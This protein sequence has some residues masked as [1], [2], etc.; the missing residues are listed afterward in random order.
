MIEKWALQL[1]YA[2][3]VAL[4]QF[5][6]NQNVEDESIYILVKIDTWYQWALC[7]VMVNCIPDREMGYSSP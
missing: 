1:L 7:V 2:W 6:T 4:C 5:L 3:L